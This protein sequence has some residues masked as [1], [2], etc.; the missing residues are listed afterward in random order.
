MNGLLSRWALPVGAIAALAMLFPVAGDAAHKR[1]RH[2]HRVVATKAATTGS[3]L[4]VGT[5]KGIAGQYSSIQA[6]VD[7]AKPY[8]WILVAPG[9]YHEQADHRANRGPQTAEAPA[10]VVIGTPYLHVRGMDR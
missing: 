6:A 4:R 2:H 1:H 10:G 5:Y 3:V 9:D 7:A 8:D